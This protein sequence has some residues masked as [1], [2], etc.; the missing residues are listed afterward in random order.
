MF[1]SFKHWGRGVR[2]T[3]SWEEEMGYW[4]GKIFPFP[5]IRCNNILHVPFHPAALSMPYPDETPRTPPEQSKTTCLQERRRLPSSGGQEEEE[6][7]SAGPALFSGSIT[8]RFRHPFLW[9]SRQVVVFPLREGKRGTR[10]GESARLSGACVEQEG[11]SWGYLTFSSLILRR[12]AR[13]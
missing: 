10:G 2:P 13:R 3:A 5:V 6:L 12:R 1:K 7:P 9:E 11:G 4:H 8:R